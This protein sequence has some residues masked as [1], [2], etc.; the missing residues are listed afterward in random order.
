MTQPRQRHRPAT[1][2]SPPARRAPRSAPRTRASS[3][4]PRHPP[5]VEAARAFI[6][7]CARR[8]ARRHP[9]RLR[10]YH[11]P[12]R[13]DHAEHER[14]RRAA[15]HGRAA[16]AWRCCAAAAWAMSR[17]WSRATLAA[18]CWAP[19]GW[20]APTAT[21]PRPCWRSCR[22]RRR[23]SGATLAL[24]LPYAAYEPARRLIAGAR[25]QHHR[26]DLR[27]RCFAAG[28]AAARA[29]RGVRGGDRGVDGGA[30]VSYVK[31]CRALGERQVTRLTRCILLILSDPVNLLQLR[32][33]DMPA[34]PSAAARSAAAG[35]RADSRY[36][37]PSSS[38]RA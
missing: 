29:D 27:G 15:R 6:A 35:C 12:R 23:S 34:R 30:S 1:T 10:L 18:R 11:R 3:P 26:R 14:R 38:C 5:R 19:A 20:C 8:D 31:K 17:W 25:R 32:A 9:S 16:G 7:G 28:V 33:R 37:Q 13:H 4:A 22:A 21:R 24:T 2:S 36:P